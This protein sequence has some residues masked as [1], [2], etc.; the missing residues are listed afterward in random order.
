MLQEIPIKED[1]D[2]LRSVFASI[3]DTVIIAETDGT[4]I[5]ANPAVELLTGILS[6]DFI[7]RKINEALVFENKKTDISEFFIEALKGDRA[8][9]LAKDSMLKQSKGSLV[10]VAVTATPLYD[11]QGELAGIVVVMHDLSEEVALKKRQYEF[12]SF[13][14]HQLRQ[15]FASLRL[16]LEAL[17]DISQEP[18]TRRQE[19]ISKDLL[20]IVLRFVNF[21]HDLMEVV[22]LEEGR[23]MLNFQTVDL[24]KLM[25]GIAAEV[26]D[27]ATSQNVSLVLFPGQFADAPLLVV[28]DQDRMLDVFRNLLINAIR[29]NRPHGTVTVQAHLATLDDIAKKISNAQQSGIILYDLRAN[30]SK[31][32]LRLEWMLVM[33]HDTGLGIPQDQQS[34][35]FESFFRAKN[36][37]NKGLQGTGLGLSIVK[38]LVE[39]TGG[40]I[41]FTSEEGKGTTFYI[42]YPIS[43]EQIKK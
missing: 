4:I 30:A 22:R 6:S 19:G 41:T 31:D 24:R 43:A 8:V 12:F 23:I 36:V 14:A 7:G 25:E 27:L 20:E 39:V 2:R 9:E 21:L 5:M 38:S 10:Q 42:I 34:R 11:I 29:Y 15:P 17:L 32:A 16:G 13:A 3:R 33:V 1:I 37:V 35:I 40:R 26:K 18:L 28:G